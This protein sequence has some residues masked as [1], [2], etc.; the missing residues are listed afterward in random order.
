MGR[1]TLPKGSWIVSWVLQLGFIG[2]V[3]FPK[4]YHIL[5][6]LSASNNTINNTGFTTNNGLYGTLTGN[7]ADSSQFFLG[8]I[9]GSSYITV[10][11]ASVTLY[12]IS[13]GV[14]TGSLGPS[15]IKFQASYGK[16]I[17]YPQY[18]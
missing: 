9:R 2:S 11:N 1:I 17:Q 10:T 12:V 8:Q 16:K 14:Y 15:N 13:N 3:T 18:L 5:S 6:Q 4:S 7:M